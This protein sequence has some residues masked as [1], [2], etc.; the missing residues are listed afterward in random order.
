VE[1]QFLMLRVVAQVLAELLVPVAEA[2]DLDTV[3]TTV[4]QLLVDLAVVAGQL[5]V[6]VFQVV[7]VLLGLVVKVM[8]V[9]VD[10]LQLVDM[11]QE[12]AEEVPAQ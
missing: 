2:V 4:F 1:I 5:T 6:L 10:F 7:L 9:V 12:V 8:L 11:V 3:I